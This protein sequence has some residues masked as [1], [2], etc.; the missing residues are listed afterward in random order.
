MAIQQSIKQSMQASALPLI[1]YLID[2]ATPTDLRLFGIV[3]RNIAGLKGILFAPVL[4]S[5]PSHLLANTSALFVLLT[6]SLSYSRRLTYWAML[7]I[8]V[9]GG[10]LVWLFGSS[11]SVHI[12]CSG[13]VFGLTGYLI[14]LG[15]Y[16]RDWKALFVSLFTGLVYGS[17]LFSLLVHTPGI[18]WTGHFFGFLAGVTAAGWMKNSRLG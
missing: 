5:G 18:S 2:I 11:N 9:G 14:F 7:I 16:R 15:L 6:L 17:M 13:V 10:G 4:H 1:V 8:T 3:P 12:G